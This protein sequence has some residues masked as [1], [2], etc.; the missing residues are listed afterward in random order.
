MGGFKQ[1]SDFF[2]FLSEA[3]AVI[4]VNNGDLNEDS[5]GEDREN[6]VD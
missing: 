6:R 5:N 1:G 4:Q 2:L 3:I